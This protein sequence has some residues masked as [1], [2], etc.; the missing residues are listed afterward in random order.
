MADQSFTLVM[1]QQH[2]YRF[3]VDFGQEGMAPLVVDEPPPLGLGEG[4]NPSRLLATSVGNC[5][6]ASLLFCLRKAHV[7][8]SRKSKRTGFLSL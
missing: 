7:E 2:D 5:L 8:K 3:L 4:P 6:S 1:E